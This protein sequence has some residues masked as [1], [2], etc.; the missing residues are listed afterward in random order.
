MPHKRLLGGIAMGSDVDNEKECPS[1]HGIGTVEHNRCHGR[2]CDGCENG[3]LVCMKCDGLGYIS[4]NNEPID[5]EPI[6]N[7]PIDNE[8]IDEPIDEPTDDEP[9]DNII[10][11]EDNNG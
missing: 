1:C 10:K 8:P 6:D 4:R 7:E 2:G 5:N 11:E 9:T 3:E